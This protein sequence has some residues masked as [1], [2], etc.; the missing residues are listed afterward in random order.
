MELLRVAQSYTFDQV[1]RSVHCLRC[2]SLAELLA[3]VH[4][5]PEM[6]EE[7]PAIKLVVIDSAAS[8][9]RTELSDARLRTRVLTGMAQGL[10]K[11]ATEK[12]LAAS[13]LASGVGMC[14]CRHECVGM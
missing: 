9:F 8:P 11:L 1:M 13:C 10:I 2:C 7:N 12:G 6:V 14:V 5:L 3:V 4:L